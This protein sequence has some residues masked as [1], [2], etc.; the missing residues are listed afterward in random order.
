LAYPIIIIITTMVI[1]TTTTII[2]IITTTTFVKKFPMFW[3]P[4]FHFHV[5]R[6]P[7]MVPVLS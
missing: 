3:N 7:Q 6:S 1:I 4:R 2:T 5:H